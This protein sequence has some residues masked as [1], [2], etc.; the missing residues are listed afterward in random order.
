MP[1]TPTPADRP[2]W[3]VVANRPDFGPGPAGTNVAGYT[4]TASITATGTTFSVF[5]PESRY[6]AANVR[7][8]LAAR[9]AEAAEIDGLT[10]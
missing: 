7:D 2:A 9:Y 5:L 10:G 1:T 4:V 3:Q 8:A 6:T